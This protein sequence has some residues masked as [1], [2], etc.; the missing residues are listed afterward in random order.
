MEELRKLY[1][2]KRSVLRVAVAIFIAG[3]VIVALST[4]GGLAVMCFGAM[5]A[6][7]TAREW[8]IEDARAKAKSG[9]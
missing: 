1:L 4:R 5:L 3:A 7:Y 2:A 8:V 6:I 9:Q